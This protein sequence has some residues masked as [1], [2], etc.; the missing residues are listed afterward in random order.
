[1]GK[2]KQRFHRTLRSHR[3]SALLEVTDISKTGLGWAE[4]RRF[5][6]GGLQRGRC[7]SGCP[8]SGTSGPWGLGREGGGKGAAE[9]GHPKKH[10]ANCIGPI[11]TAESLGG[12]F[13]L[14]FSRYFQQ[15]KCHEKTTWEA[16]TE[17]RS[18]KR[19]CISGH[20]CRHQQGLFWAGIPPTHTPPV[21]QSLTSHE[22]RLHHKVKSWPE[23]KICPQTSGRASS[24]IACG[25]AAPRASPARPRGGVVPAD[26]GRG[27]F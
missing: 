20:R 14:S 3:S 21:I 4:Q 2:K 22:R 18:T 13:P 10:G 27:R 24:P 17:E 23:S 26:N 9:T 25:T 7:C 12:C 11:W 6:P 8:K 16:G 5:A 19:S 1:M 15:T